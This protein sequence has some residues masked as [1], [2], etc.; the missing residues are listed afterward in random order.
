MKQQKSAVSRNKPLALPAGWRFIGVAFTCAAVLVTMAHM[1]MSFLFV[2]PSNAISQRYAHLVNMWIYPWFEQ[3]WAMFAP[4]PVSW[5]EEIYARTYY[6]PARQSSWVDL[7]ASDYAAIRGNIWPTHYA[8]NE[9][10]RAWD[11]YIQNHDLRDAS[12]SGG[13]GLLLAEYLRNIA[14]QRVA[15]QVPPGF[16]DIQIRTVVFPVRPP[17]TAANPVPSYRTLP[18]WPVSGAVSN[19]EGT[20]G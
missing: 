7:T 4:N 13:R 10:R 11:G 17:G 5:N 2:A 1:V 15:G 19:A 18:W 20:S 8:Q 12:T 14:V 16:A 3:N 6:S 9:L